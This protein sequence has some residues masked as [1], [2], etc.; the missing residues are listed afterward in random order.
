MGT[1]KKIISVIILTFALLINNVSF[2]IDGIVSIPI[3]NKTIRAY[4]KGSGDHTIVL[5]SGWSTEDPINDFNPLVEKLSDEYRVVVLEYFGYGSSSQTSTERSNKNIVEEIRTALAKLEIKPPYI[6]MPHSMS[7][8]Y[9]L[10]YANH[11]PEEVEGIIGI[12]MSLP[13]KQLERWP[14]NKDFD[15]KAKISS[16]SNELNETMVNQWN[17]FRENSEELQDTKYSSTLPVLSFLATEQIESVNDLIKKGEMKTSWEQMNRDMITN[18]AIQNIKILAGEHYLHH[19]QADQIAKLSKEFISQ[20]I[21]PIVDGSSETNNDSE[22]NKETKIT[23]EDSQSKPTSGT[24]MDNISKTADTMTIQRLF[25]LEL[26]IMISI[27]G[28]YFSHKSK[29]AIT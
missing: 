8:L 19:D 7:G 18:D 11:Y 15:E 4:V 13:Q 10:Y 27:L 2:A 5:L 1:M 29:N 23:P 6:L 26:L 9:S 3:E 20:Y 24:T 22:E 16:P 21:P 28:L 25:E 17:K 12:D 14:T